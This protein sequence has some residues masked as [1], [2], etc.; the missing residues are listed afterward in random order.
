M[1]FSALTLLLTT[2]VA[3]LPV[4]LVRR[5]SARLLNTTSA[6]ATTPVVVIRTAQGRWL[7]NGTPLTA[8]ALERQL[9]AGGPR[10]AI[11]F[12]PSPALSTAEVRRWWLWLAQSSGGAVGLALPL[13]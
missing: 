5:P 4:L 1:P 2:A 10:L 12:L 8:L 6:A 7:I 9:R 3:V 13:G 11:R